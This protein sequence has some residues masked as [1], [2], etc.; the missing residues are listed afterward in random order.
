MIEITILIPLAGNDGLTFA[1]A[2]HAVFEREVVDVFGGFT[3]LPDAAK[4][5]WVK[6]GTFYPDY[7]LQYVVALDSITH[8]GKVA[9]I[10]AFA[11]RHYRQEAIF[12]RYLGLAE[13][14]G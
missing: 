11:R 6:D 8:G 2:H 13:V 4:G 14:L 9:D 5:G 3:L 12:I 7:H 1:P 10:A